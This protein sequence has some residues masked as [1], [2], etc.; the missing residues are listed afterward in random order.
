M[1]RVT[2]PFFISHQGCPHTCIFCDQRLISGAG[3]S[4][5]TPA[6]IVEKIE[7]WR[8][9]AGARPLEVAFFGGSF[10]AL[11]ESKQ[12]ELLAPLQPLLKRGVLSAVRLSTRPDCID[13]RCVAYLSEMGVRTIELGVQSMDDQVLAASGRGHTAAASEAAIACIRKHGLQVGAQLM[14]GLPGDTPASSLT[15]LERVISAGVDFIRIY[16]TVV[17][18][19]TG[20]AKRYADGNYV[21]LGFEEGLF[22]CK[23]LLHR[24]MQAGLKVIRIGLQADDGLNSQSVLAGCWHP[25]LGQLVRS[26]LYGDLLCQMVSRV[27]DAVSVVVKCNT[28]RISDVI[29]LS[30]ENLKRMQ[31]RGRDVAVVADDGLLEEELCFE[32]STREHLNQNM[33]TSP[34]PPCGGGLGWGGSCCEDTK[35]V[36]H[37]PPDPLPS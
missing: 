5:P 18:R 27:P 35:M 11:P 7:K 19:S 24:A 30:K 15:T 12:A 32:F 9:T 25:A 3:G 26:Q 2:V 28:K 22:L 14:P 4:L 34:L 13:D 29:G 20:L 6:E 23:I 21:P 17:L 8:S 37:P 33:Q 16:P 10:T 1:K 36:L 31:L